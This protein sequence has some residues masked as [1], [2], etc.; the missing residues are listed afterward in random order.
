MIYN[1]KASAGGDYAPPHIM[2]K[3]L[4]NFYLFEEFSEPDD[5][6]NISNRKLKGIEVMR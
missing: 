3:I 4:A 2:L 6:D 1:C 5:L